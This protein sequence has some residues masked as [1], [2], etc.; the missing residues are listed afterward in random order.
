MMLFL[1]FQPF[2]RNTEKAKIETKRLENI[3]KTKLRNRRVDKGR[4]NEEIIK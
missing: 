3:K 2:Q 1:L 4:C